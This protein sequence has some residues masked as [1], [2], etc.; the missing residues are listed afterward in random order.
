M[1]AA[2]AL[3]YQG[4]PGALANERLIESEVAQRTRKPLSE[5]VFSE[6]GTAAEI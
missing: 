5:F 6:W 3:G 4:E 1:G 2:I